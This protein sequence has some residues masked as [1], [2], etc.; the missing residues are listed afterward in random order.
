MASV[1]T[2]GGLTVEEDVHDGAVTFQADPSSKTALGFSPSTRGGRL[3]PPR[4]VV[5]A[6]AAAMKAHKLISC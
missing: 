2:T 1:V 5:D 3:F 6:A 4:L